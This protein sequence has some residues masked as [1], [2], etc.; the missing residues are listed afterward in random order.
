VVVKPKNTSSF[1][2]PDPSAPGNQTL[3]MGL[4]SRNSPIF[5]CT[6]QATMSEHT[7]TRYGL[8]YLRG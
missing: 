4:F 3:R 1:L 6:N 7:G 2:C 5:S 8:Q